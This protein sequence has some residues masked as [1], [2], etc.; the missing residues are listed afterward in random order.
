[1]NV[2]IKCPNCGSCTC[3]EAIPARRADLAMFRGSENHTVRCKF[4][5]TDMDTMTAF[6]G[7]RSGSQVLRHE[8][9][10]S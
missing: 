10:K 6:V 5:Q 2:F 8:D 3:F 9:P 7:E 4:C 1:M